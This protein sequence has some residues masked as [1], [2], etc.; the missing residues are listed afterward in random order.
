MNN[1]QLLNRRWKNN[2]RLLLDFQRTLSGITR[3][4]KGDILDMFDSIDIAYEDLGKPIST[5]EHERL[6]RLIK[7]WQRQGIDNEYLN[8]K[9]ATRSRR[10]TYSEFMILLL[11]AIYALYMNRAYDASKGLFTDICKK[12]VKQAK[13]EMGRDPIVPFRL[14]WRTIEDM[15]TVSTMNMSLLAY[16]QLLVMSCCNE[17]YQLYVQS[18]QVSEGAEINETA[19]DN[20]LKKQ[21]NRLVDIHDDKESGVI[22][23]VSR[24]AVNQAYIAPYKEENVQVR[25]I[26][27]MDSATTEMCKGM[28]G[29]LFYTKAWNRYYRYSALDKRDVLYTTFGLKAGE[30]LPPINNHFHWCRSTITYLIDDEDERYL[31]TFIDL[32]KWIPEYLPDTYDEFV[33][34]IEADEDYLGRMRLLRQ[35]RKHFN[36]YFGRNNRGNSDDK[37]KH[38]TFT[39]YAE[40]YMNVCDEVNGIE[41]K[42]GTLISDVSFHFYDRMLERNVSVDEIIDTV[43]TGKSE[44]YQ[45]SNITDYIKDIMKIGVSED[46][47][48]LTCIKKGK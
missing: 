12:A 10:P 7:Q 39:S 33:K 9:I 22:V 25:F 19:L 29:M 20:L 41:T 43:Q 15:L 27:E 31:A 4:L 46:G 45:D 38:M 17:A 2:D 32:R 16:L 6:N 8:Y 37:L 42:D 3:G 13:E 14:T 11:L 23:D 47:K 28:D 44:Q 5:R 18:K 30:N 21:Q 40:G 1:A 24:Q 34:L 35:L 36:S 26:A 48:L